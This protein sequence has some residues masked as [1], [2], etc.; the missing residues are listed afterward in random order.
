MITD[1]M[2]TAMQGVVPSAIVTSDPEGTPNCTYISQV[3]FVDD[4]HVA[5]SHQFFNK[6]IRN[7]RENPYASV[8]IV[9]PATFDMWKLDLKFSHS[10]TDGDVFD[11]MAMQLEAIASM[12]GME[13]VFKLKGAEIFE[14]YGAEKIT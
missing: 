1:E 8:N 12:T 7:V 13:D 3:F 11:Q 2:K 6:T 4:T 5:L 10:E 14:V 9:S